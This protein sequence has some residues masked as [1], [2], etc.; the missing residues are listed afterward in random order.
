MKTRYL[1]DTN[2]LSDLI[3]NPHGR[4]A[5][6]I[7]ERGE[8]NICTSIVV[9]V[10]LRHGASKKESF[11]LSSRISRLLSILKVEPLEVPADTI[12]GA[13]RTRLESEGRPIGANDLLIAAHA[14]ALGCVIVTDNTKEFGRIEDLR[15]E[16]WLR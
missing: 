8:A 2:I 1:L 10:E 14:V 9:A 7:R 6:E 13:L 4:A 5:G 11:T 12:Y 3:R 16:N 15:C